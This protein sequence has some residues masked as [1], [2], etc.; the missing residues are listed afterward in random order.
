[1]KSLWLLLFLMVVTA[2]VNAQDCYLQVTAGGGIT[3]SATAYKIQPDGTVLKGKGI[4]EVTY[5]QAAKMKQSAAKKYFRKLRSLLES[6]PEFNHPGNIYTSLTLHENGSEKK[7]VWGAVDHA[8]PEDVKKF[9]EKI[10]AAL[11]KLTFS[12]VLRK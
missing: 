2:S 10:S 6:N 7:I 4:G 9:Y 5:D 11:G 8:S 1:M 3:G 12:E